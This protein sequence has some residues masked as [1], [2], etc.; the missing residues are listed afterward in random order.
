MD[1]GLRVSEG[2]NHKAIQVLSLRLG[3]EM[4]LGGSMWRRLGLV[5]KSMVGQVAPTL[6]LKEM[7]FDKTFKMKG[8]GRGPTNMWFGHVQVV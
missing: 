6:R 3:Y 8:F 1:K 4:G 5:G 2:T 7:A